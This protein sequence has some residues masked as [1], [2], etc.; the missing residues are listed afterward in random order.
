VIIYAN[1][2]ILGRITIGKNAVIGG[3]IWVDAD[4]PAEAKIIQKK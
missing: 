3:N 2:T 4:V 1:S